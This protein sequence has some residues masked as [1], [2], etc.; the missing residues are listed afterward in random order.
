MQAEPEHDEYALPVTLKG[1]LMV[2]FDVEKNGGG[3]QCDD[4]DEHGCQHNRIVFH[5]APREY[6]KKPLQKKGLVMISY[7]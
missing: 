3:A 7:V 4:T 5:G 6:G 1:G 2:A